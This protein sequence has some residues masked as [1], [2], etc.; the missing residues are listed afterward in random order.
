V[1]INPSTISDHNLTNLRIRDEDIE[2]LSL[3]LVKMISLQRQYPIIITNEL[4]K[5]L[6]AKDHEHQLCIMHT[7]ND[8]TPQFCQLDHLLTRIGIMS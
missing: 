5:S 2:H 7:F 6:I 1:I 4:F 8:K 3:L